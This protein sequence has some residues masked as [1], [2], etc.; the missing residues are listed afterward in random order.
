MGPLEGHTRGVSSVSFSVDGSRIVSGSDDKTVRV[1]DAVSGECVLGPLEGQEC[2]S[3]SF[4]VD[5]SRIVSGSGDKTVRV[6][7][8]V[9]GECVLGPLEGHTDSVSRCRLVGTGRA[10]CR[11]RGTRPCVWDAVSGESC[12]VRWRGTLVSCE[13][14]RCRLVGTGR[15]S[16]RGRTT[17][18][19]VCGTRC[20]GSACWVRWRGTREV[21]RCRLVDGSRIV[22]GYV[23]Q[24]R[25]CVGRGVWGVRVGSAG[26]AHGN[27]EVGVV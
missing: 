24:Y 5:G 27:S 13:V 11:G 22:S 2:E 9:S 6:W 21:C 7:D 3:V 8:A 26:G 1:W 19:C 20:L 10:S 23:R 16:C 4:S 14:N 12:W 17:R 15:A 25:A 18:P